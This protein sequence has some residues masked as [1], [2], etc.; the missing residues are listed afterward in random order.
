MVHVE[1]LG[2]PEWPVPPECS[3]SPQFSNCVVSALQKANAQP[4]CAFM[5]DPS[6]KSDCVGYY[7]QLYVYQDCRGLCSTVKA[8]VKPPSMEPK[9]PPLRQTPSAPAS[10]S[11]GGGWVVAGVVVVG[12]VVAALAL[13]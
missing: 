8:P 13:K 10:T 9:L 5:Q 12:V 4:E 11:G 1:W 3:G 2:A 7:H 6:Q